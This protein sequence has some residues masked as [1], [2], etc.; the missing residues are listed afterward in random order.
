MTHEYDDPFNSES[1]DAAVAR[2]LELRKE[3]PQ[4]PLEAHIEEAVH[5]RLCSCAV[6]IEDQIE[7]ARSGLHDAIAQEVRQRIERSLSTAN[8]DAGVDV[9]NQ[10][11][12]QSFPASDP[13]GWIWER[14]SKRQ[15]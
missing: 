1:I 9:V 4:V 14:P 5:Q 3:A 13:P 2:T 11:S 10:A 6:D 8:P 15:P 12:E 7:N